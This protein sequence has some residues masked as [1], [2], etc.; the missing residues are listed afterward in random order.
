MSRFGIAASLALLLSLAAP[1]IAAPQPVHAHRPLARLPGPSGTAVE[2]SRDGKLI[3]TA[4][5]DQARVW[6]AR[7]FR[8]VTGRL[9]H[10]KGE[11][12]LLAELSSEGSR[13]VTV[14]GTEAN[15]WNA[16]T[17]ER[18]ATLRHPAR[19]STA[20]F[21]PDNSR[22]ITG[23]DDNNAR[24]W[25]AAGGRE[26]LT[27]EHPAP[28]LFAT[29][30][31]DGSTFLTLSQWPSV[32]EKRKALPGSVRVW[33]TRT[34]AELWHVPGEVV[35]V[36]PAD[37]LLRR[38]RHPAAFSADG[39]NVAVIRLREV[40]VLDARSGTGLTWADPADEGGQPRAVAFSPDGRS[41]VTATT[42]GAQ[43]WDASSDHKVLHVTLRNGWIDEALFSADGRWV[44]NSVGSG[45][46]SVDE[47]GGD[48]GVAVWDATTGKKLFA[49]AYP[50]NDRGDRVPAVAFSPD[51]KRVAAG[52]PSDGFTGVWAVEAPTGDAA[53]K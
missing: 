28:V 13:V 44:L 23:C 32:A 19:V 18:L 46:Y 38:L 49:L 48:L 42:D 7:T 41:L 6:N 3:L 45:I 11:E 50:Q 9:R 52:F 37:P 21:S 14:A 43:V 15:V 12:L 33:E 10:G 47:G 34:G 4:G 27:L 8:P 1:S 29:F 16:T 31:P 25:E 17:G 30:S 51:G 35:A 5:G 2:F 26:V 20:M 40:Q 53:K 24:V 39:K 22:L 36:D